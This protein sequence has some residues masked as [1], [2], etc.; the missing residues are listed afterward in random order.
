MFRLSIRSYRSFHGYPIVIIISFFF[1]LSYPWSY[2]KKKN[3]SSIL[4]WNVFTNVSVLIA[5]SCD[6]VV[7]LR[8]YSIQSCR[9]DSF[10]ITPLH[11]A[12]LLET[13]GVERS[14]SSLVHRSSFALRYILLCTLPSFAHRLKVTTV[15]AR[16]TED[17]S[18][19]R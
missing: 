9:S 18:T 1:C 7:E 13:L 8:F 2:R 16:R 4:R 12:E 3:S 10:V 6:G 14:T 15:I 19:D 17:T 5:Y 11:N